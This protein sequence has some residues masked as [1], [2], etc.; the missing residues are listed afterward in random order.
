VCL[1]DHEFTAAKTN[2]QRNVAD[3][4]WKQRAQVGR[5][6][7]GKIEGQQRQQGLDQVRLMWT[8]LVTFAASKEG[9]G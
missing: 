2:L 3:R 9:A 1:R 7:R 5:N 6:R 8:Q 4:N